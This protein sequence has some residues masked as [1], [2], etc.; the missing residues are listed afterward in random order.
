MLYDLQEDPQELCDRGRD[1][2]LATV[3]ERMK[4]LMLDWS[5]QLRN[6]TAIDNEQMKALTGKSARQGI[7][8]GFWKESDVPEAQKPPQLGTATSASLVLSNA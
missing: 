6:R 7:L 8:I 4:D 1:P 2:S 3:R 5:S